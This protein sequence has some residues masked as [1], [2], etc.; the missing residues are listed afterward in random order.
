MS[1]KPE[2]TETQSQ[3]K[4]G[5]VRL[6]VTQSTLI[7]HMR[8]LLSTWVETYL[9]I[10][11]NFQCGYIWNQSPVWISLGPN[12]VPCTKMYP[13][14]KIISWYEGYYYTTTHTCHNIHKTNF[15]IIVLNKNRSD[16]EH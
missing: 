16:R 9:N 10:G 1:A 13:N 7:M 4:M 3:I 12:R 14:F 2:D 6:Q 5:Y 8:K 15:N 11:T